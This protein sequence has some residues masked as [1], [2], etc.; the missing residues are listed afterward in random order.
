MGGVIQLPAGWGEAEICADAPHI[1][2]AQAPGPRAYDHLGSRLSWQP[3]AEFGAKKSAC[4]LEDSTRDVTF[5]ASQLGVA[6]ADF[7][8]GWVASEVLAKLADMPILEWLKTRGLFLCETGVPVRAEI[9]AP[10]NSATAQLMVVAH[11]SRM[12]AFGFVR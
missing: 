6:P 5:M 8:R 1:P 7:H 10:Q 4:D 12:M 2:C 9:P 3:P 11:G